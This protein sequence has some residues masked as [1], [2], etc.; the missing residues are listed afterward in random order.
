MSHKLSTTL[1]HI[2]RSPYQSMAAIFMTT[3][4]F[5]IV[6]IF[7]LVVLGAHSMLGYFESRPQ[8][9]AF[10]KD[11]V[12]DSDISALKHN[13]ESAVTVQDTRYIS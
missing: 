13:V 7:A 4:T 6:S 8:V 5:Y 9:T 12:L 10:F 3:V 11:T 2:R 1:K